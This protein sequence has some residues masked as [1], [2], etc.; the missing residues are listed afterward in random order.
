MPCKF[1]WG[2]CTSVVLSLSL[3]H[4]PTPSIYTLSDTPTLSF[5]SV[6][7]VLSPTHPLSFIQTH[8]FLSSF[9]AKDS[10]N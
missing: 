10:F 5:L 7:F 2:Q 6:I 8:A 1:Q 4:T 3:K 9:P